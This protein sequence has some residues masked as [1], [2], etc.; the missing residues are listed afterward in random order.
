MDLLIVIVALTLIILGLYGALPVLK[1]DGWRLRRREKPDMVVRA[2]TAWRASVTLPTFG[3][4]PRPERVAV[5]EVDLLRAQVEALRG[6]L[7]TGRATYNDRPRLRRYR[8]GVYTQLP[9]PLRQRVREVRSSR[10]L[11]GPA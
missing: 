7:A 5:S 2:E 8:V 1:R 6:E 4:S 9:R 10:K 11:Y 3:R